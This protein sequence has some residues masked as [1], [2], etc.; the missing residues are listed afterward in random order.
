[1]NFIFST[2]KKIYLLII[3]AFLAVTFNAKATALDT[4]TQNSPSQKYEW[5]RI[6][7]STLD[8][9][10]WPSEPG[11]NSEQQKKELIEYFDL[12]KSLNFNTVVLQVRP[13]GDA[14]YM[15]EYE[16]WSV[17]LTGDETKPPV[18]FYDPLQF[19]VEQ[20]HKRGL[21]LHVWLNPYKN[22]LNTTFKNLESHNFLVKIVKDIVRRYDIDGINF[23]N[24][25][26][27]DSENCK[28]SIDSLNLMT[29]QIYKA[30]KQIKPY[31]KVGVCPCNSNDYNE[32][33]DYTLQSRDFAASDIKNN[34]SGIINIIK[35]K[36]KF[37]AIPPNILTDNQKYST[38]VAPTK[39]TIVIAA[40]KGSKAKEVKLLW[41]TYSG[42][43]LF[44]I[45]RAKK[46]E[47]LVISNPQNIVD[48]INANTYTC[49]DVDAAE[50][51][52]YITALSRYAK[53]S[54]PVLCKK[55][56][57]LTKGR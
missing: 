40:K 32:W 37:P 5:R 57:I 13:S 41:N 43:Y 9:T 14:F 24:Y 45:Y 35:E 16:P 52:Y 19:A 2:V 56:N 4:T 54:E 55:Q 29:E 51:D 20:A 28:E 38:P 27:P 42:T 11:L 7:I 36:F 47:E 26:Y 22:S 50:Y 44:V 17:Y 53:E 39:P 12:S 23:D 18:P 21:E 34:L 33:T 49:T 15:S 8:N 3:L 6:W 1:M 30:V 25:F 48:I 31:V 46:G 10:D